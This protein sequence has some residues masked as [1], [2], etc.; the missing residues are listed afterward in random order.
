MKKLAA[1][2]AAVGALMI[3]T[4]VFACPNTDHDEKTVDTK[5]AD[6]TKTADKQKDQKPA[7]KAA[8]AD[9]AKEKPAK[10]VAKG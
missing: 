8:P 1:A 9:K 7:E 10:P 6:D 5:K 4:P 3:A 2:F